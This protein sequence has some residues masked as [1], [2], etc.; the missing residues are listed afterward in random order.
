MHLGDRAV[1][2]H[3][4]DR[5]LERL[6]QLAGILAQRRRPHQ[7]GRIEVGQL[8]LRIVLHR[9]G[10]HGIAGDVGI[11]AADHH[12]LHGVGLGAERFDL[13]ADLAFEVARPRIIGRA[14]VDARR[15]FP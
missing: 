15:S 8:E 14:L 9:P 6:A 3:A 1:E 4:F 13:P 10:D 5:V 2:L 11:G 7:A 12:R